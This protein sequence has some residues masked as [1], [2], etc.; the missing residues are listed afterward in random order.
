MSNNDKK[1]REET[2]QFTPQFGPDGLIPCITISAATG[3]VAMFAYMNQE[4]LDKTLQTGEVH[5]WS[6]SRNEL[7]HKGATSGTTQSVKE[8]RIDCDQ[9]CLLITAEI[10]GTGT[11]CHTNRKTCFYR[12]LSKTSPHTLEFKEKYN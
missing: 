10:N 11:G 3:D 1:H 2:T 7:W 5:Y 12:T 8:I 6:R 4:S 9:D